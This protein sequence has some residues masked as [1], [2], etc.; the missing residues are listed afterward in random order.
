M[1]QSDYQESAKFWAREKPTIQSDFLCRPYVYELSE[2][3]NDLIVADIGCG[4]G[5]VSRHFAKLGAKKIIGVDVK[6]SVIEE[7]KKFN[8][9]DSFNINYFVGTALDLPMIDDQSVD[10]AV[11]VLVYGHFDQ[12]EM[13]QAIKETFRILKPGG[14]FI[15]AVPHPFMFIG[16]PQTRWVTFTD[17]KRPNYFEDK[18]SN[19]ILHRPDEA[20]GI[21]NEQPIPV[22][23][24]TLDEYINTL[25]ENGFSIKKI[26]E[27][28]PTTQDLATYPK[29]WGEETSLPIYLI[30]KARKQN[31]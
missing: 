11:S 9:R 21:N 1:P 23:L 6:E 24:H 13:D 27:P 18:I 20:E 14:N 10:L 29:M 17:E 25:L 7:A 3:V 22:R 16:K 30:I 5:Y 15:L 8:E 2:D 31:A 12:S 28:K 26:L 19:I 4:D